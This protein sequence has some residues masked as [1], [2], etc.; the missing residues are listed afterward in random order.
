LNARLVCKKCLQVFHLTAGGVA[1]LGEPPVQ[2]TAPKEKV[3]RE[4]LELDISGLE[5]LGQKLAKIKLPDPKIAGA[6]FVVLLLIG[7]C[8]WLFSQESVEKRSH[9]VA[10]AI[11]KGDIQAVMPLV[12][13]GTEGEAMK[14]FSDIYKEYVDLKTSMGL[15]DPGIQIQ[16]QSTSDGRSSQ[17]LL[18]FSRMGGG[19]HRAEA[20]AEVELLA[21]KPS[22][23]KAKEN[24]Q[25]ILFWTPDTWGTWRL[26]AKRTAENPT[27]G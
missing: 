25:V 4:R 18:I 6:V 17:A 3:P 7:I 13:P 5:G 26:D 20:T 1:V 2:K 15:Q 10:T 19:P 23:S 22:G 21:P 12:Y 8:S 24:V 16:V 27:R 14:W 9:T 11:T